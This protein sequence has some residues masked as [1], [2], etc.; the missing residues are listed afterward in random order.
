MSGAAAAAFVTAR[1]AEVVTVVFAVAVLF[2]EL[3]S[4]V[5]L[6]TVAEFEI[7]PV[8]LG[9]TLTPIMNVAVTPDAIDG[10]EQL[11]GPF[12]P[13]A[14]VVQLN[15]AAGVI[16]ANR[17]F[18]GSASVKPAFTAAFGPLFVTPIV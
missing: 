17:V 2:A 16:D 4:A 15:P 7:V 14:G 18:G 8:A 6:L 1:S 13:T 12:A 5:A 3:L 10:V 9:M 11:T